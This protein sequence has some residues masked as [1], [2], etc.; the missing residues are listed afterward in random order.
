ME[1]YTKTFSEGSG[2][3]LV[4]H[5]HSH[6]WTSCNTH[7][8]CKDKIGVVHYQSDG[9]SSSPEGLPSCRSVFDDDKPEARNTSWDGRVMNPLGTGPGPSSCLEVVQMMMKGKRMAMLEGATYNFCQN[10]SVLLSSGN[11]ITY[12]SQ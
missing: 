1:D 4:K 11:D 8:G 12:T 7:D 10:S 3:T 6:Y 2:T 5:V 9:S